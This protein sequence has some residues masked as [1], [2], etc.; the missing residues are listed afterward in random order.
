MS[1]KR[2]TAKQLKAIEMLARPDNELSLQ[3][4]ADELGINQSTLWRWR[5]NE[6]FQKAVTELAYSCLKDELPQLFKSLASKAIGGNVKA[7]ELM[8]KYAGNYV[9]KIET[10]VSGDLD[11]GGMSDAELDRQIKE[12]ERLLKLAEGKE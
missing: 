1:A 3:Q 5:R 11:L 7:M 10:R 9:E 12:Q 8:L 4:I 2:F 6:D